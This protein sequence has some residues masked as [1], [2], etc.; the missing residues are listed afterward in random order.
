M[1]PAARR[2]RRPTPSS[3]E[4]ELPDAEE[5][6]RLKLS[7]EV[8][9]Y[10]VDRGIGLPDCPPLWKTPEAGEVLAEAVFDPA[11]VDRVLAAFASLQHTKGKWAGR[12][13]RPDPWQV[14]YVVAPAFGWVRPND[15]G[16]GW[17]RVVSELYVEVPRKNG[18]STTCG[19]IGIYL[20]CGDGE[21]GAEVIVAAT[22]KDQAGF[23][24]SPIQQLASSSPA[25]RPHVK[26]LTSKI[27]HRRTGS[28][29][30]PVA[31]VADAQHGG[32]I[33]GAVIDE[34][35]LH[36]SGDVVE[37]IE[38]GTGSREQPLIVFI[39]TAD[40]GQ[41]TT[42]YAR[43]RDRV[44]KLTER[45]LINPAVFGVV[46]SAEESDDPHDEAT[47]RKAN[48]GFGISP[49]RRSLQQASDAARD[50]P[51]AMAGFLRFRLGIRTGLAERYI[52]LDAWDRNAGLVDRGRLRGRLCYGGLDLATT[53]D[54][55]A[56][57]LVFP[58]PD[59][60]GYD[61]LWRHW[62]PERAFGPLNQRTSG[63]AA[64]WRREGL[65]TVTEGDV[66]DYA[67]V[68]RDI[69]T[70]RELFD[71]AGIGYDRWNSS[72][73]CVELENDDGAPMEAIGQ[74]FASLSAPMKALKHE[75][76]AGSSERPRFRHG[77]QPLLRWQATNLRTEE[78]AAG[79]VKPSKKKSMD[80]IDGFSAVIDA[81]S[82][83]LA[84]QSGRS[85]YEDDD[86]EV[87]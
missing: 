54:L 68:R 10:L 6:A 12:P 50:D 65:L 9:W 80:K 46:F 57:A 69:N 2:R 25:L 41:T 34:L 71:V 38:T 43:K 44:E 82:L 19:G 60:E 11:R 59:G 62:I 35:H 20:T 47:W 49:T 79:N 56:F 23:V 74:G 87:G 86:L 81:L 45:V 37:A 76:L 30:K 64:V 26:A 83:A 66:T 40:D 24:F 53:S 73:V 21:D 39:G 31:N 14:A 33:H 78:D 70:D 22:S 42:I 72:Q 63:Q 8:A 5:L 85:I 18:K 84:N 17:V 52:P 16:S 29:M 61:A 51:A 13:L 67:F 27:V 48:P 3:P 36:R 15:D 55:T 75:L 4:L 7:R 28:Y 58:D 1:A 77:G 32:N